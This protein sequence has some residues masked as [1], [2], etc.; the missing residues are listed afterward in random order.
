[1][2]YNVLLISAA[3]QSNFSFSYIYIYIYI[4]IYMYIWSEVLVTQLCPTLCDPMDYSPPGSFV[5]GILQARTLEWA[6]NSL[7]RGSSQF[8]NWTQVFCIVGRFFTIWVTG[9]TL[10]IQGFLSID[11]GEGNGNP[12]QY[13]CLENSVAKEPDGL[14]SMGSHSRTRL[15][16]LRMHACI[17]EGNGNPLQYSCLENPRDGGVW[18]A[19]V[20]G[21]AQSWTRLKRLS[22]IYIYI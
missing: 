20:Y 15:T 13:S 19:A 4:C 1:M 3:H 17:G 2:I 16:R 7:S 12:L 8:R 14:L 9:E 5:L 10:Y 21:V 18:W 6:A 11:I 22:S